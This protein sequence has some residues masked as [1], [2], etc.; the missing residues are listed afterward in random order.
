MADAILNEQAHSRMNASAMKF[1]QEELAEFESLK[2]K[3]EA[4]QINVETAR[5]KYNAIIENLKQEASRRPV[6]F[7][8]N[9]SIHW[10]KKWRANSGSENTLSASANSNNQ[11]QQQQPETEKQSSF[12]DSEGEGSIASRRSVAC[13]RHPDGSDACLYDEICDDG[14]RLF[15]KD[16]YGDLQRFPPEQKQIDWRFYERLDRDEIPVEEQ[17]IPF[18]IHSQIEVVPEYAWAATRDLEPSI[19]EHVSNAYFVI[20]QPDVSRGG[21]NVWHFS[22][23]V[24]MLLD[25]QF[26]NETGIYPPIDTIVIR[27]LGAPNT[28]S[29]GLLDMVLPINDNRT[30]VIL[31]MDGQRVCAKTAVI[32]GYRRGIFLGH[33]DGTRFRERV[34]FRLGL[35][36]HPTQREF[37]TYPIVIRMINRKLSRRIDYPTANILNA[38]LMEN[39]G[40]ETYTF[41]MFDD[42]S[43]FSFEEQVRLFA[44]TD[45][46]I[47]PHGAGLTN[48]IFAR[49]HVPVIEVFPHHFYNEL[50]REVAVVSNHPYYCVMGLPESSKAT[51]LLPALIRDSASND[52]CELWHGIDIMIEASCHHKFKQH[53]I[54]VDLSYLHHVIV[55]AL[56]AL[57]MESFPPTHQVYDP[58]RPANEP[59]GKPSQKS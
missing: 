36:I 57:P 49:N 32:F 48:M 47:M 1:L 40:P 14:N 9:G 29:S 42:I 27:A 55:L 39:G 30:K 34:Y 7:D 58:I 18:D 5:E 24:A 46:L 4:L 15:V 31:L 17:S 35:N 28:W 22:Q 25:P 56:D 6:D 53:P 11:N 33:E 52:K 43:A 13:I 26:H 23:S 59:L 37:R 51:T 8:P 54:K 21:N 45:I 10:F 50:Y 19:T 41:E 20:L 3:S 2:K 12:P 16:L 44:S 38:T